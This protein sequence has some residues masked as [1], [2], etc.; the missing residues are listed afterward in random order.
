MRC[1]SKPPAWHAEG[2]WSWTTPRPPRRGCDASGLQP[3]TWSTT[4]CG[5]ACSDHASWHNKGY[6]AAFAFES[7]FGQ[8]NPQIHRPTDSVA[9]L[10]ASAAHA[11]KFA[12]LA[13]SFLLEAG[14][15]GPEVLFIDGFESGDTSA[16]TLGEEKAVASEP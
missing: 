13:T 1:C 10:G 15:D 6:P 4:A 12:Q 5:Y 3:S 8:H 16:W 11:L 9:T 7:R 2:C 14:S